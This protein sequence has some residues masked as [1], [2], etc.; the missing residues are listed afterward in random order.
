M[1]DVPLQSTNGLLSLT[2]FRSILE[3]TGKRHGYWKGQRSQELRGH[4]HFED[5]KCP[6]ME[7]S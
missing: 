7:V 1:T 2:P 3:C 5:K 4:D 6:L